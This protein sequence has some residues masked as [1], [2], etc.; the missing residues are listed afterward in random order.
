MKNAAPL[1]LSTASALL[2][3]VGGVLQAAPPTAPL[4]A[5]GAAHASAT[6]QAD[7]A[8]VTSAGFDKLAEKFTFYAEIPIEGTVG[9]D[10]TPASVK[11]ALEAAAKDPH[12]EHV[13]FM[14]DVDPDPIQ[15]ALLDK[16][17]VDAFPGKLTIHS[18][19]RT[20][21]NFA[22]FPIFSSDSI[23]MTEEAVIG[24]MSIHH[25]MQPGSAE[26]MAK[27]VG[28]TSSQLATAAQSHGHNPDIARAMVDSKQDLYYWRADGE[29]VVS[30]DRPVNPESV[31]SLEKIQSVM[32]GDTLT[33]NQETAIRIQLAQPI[34]DYDAWSIGEK[35]E[36]DNW[37]RANRYA[38]CAHQI[39]GILAEISPEVE[40]IAQADKEFP[41][42]DRNDP[43]YREMREIKQAV[44]QALTGMRQ[45]E[46]GLNTIMDRHPERHAYFV[47]DDG[48]TILADPAKWQEDMDICSRELSRIRSGVSQ[49]R[50][51]MIKFY[52]DPDNIK[53]LADDLDK[54]KV[55]LDGIQEHGNAKYWNDYYVPE[56]PPD[57]YG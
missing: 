11:K 32:F 34:D 15:G 49:I 12:I 48:K 10:C 43:D 23:Y 29:V 57:I 4:T 18:V 40:K 45:I 14:V 42:P 19:V 1:V 39:G 5:R 51:A 26:V 28:I 44:S 30:N 56:L 46:E 54:I 21:L 35:L 36:I 31:Q 16:N 2:L 17:V 13:V 41:E 6:K 50:A 7:A 27:W 55:H 20:G 25:Y 9:M 24:G 53:F 3:A 33:L 38:Q 37:E 8:V 22:V 47:G 52:Y